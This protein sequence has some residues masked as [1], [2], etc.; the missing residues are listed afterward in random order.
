M[1]HPTERLDTVHKPREYKL[2]LEPK[3]LGNCAYVKQKTLKNE[4]IYK[5]LFSFCCFML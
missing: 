5:N 3:R 4:K 1:N 2:G